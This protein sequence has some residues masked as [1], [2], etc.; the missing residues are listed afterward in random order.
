M[1]LLKYLLLPFTAILGLS[2]GI[3]YRLRKA[4]PTLIEFMIGFSFLTSVMVWCILFV[5]K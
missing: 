4:Y 3:G 2:M 5:L 1:K